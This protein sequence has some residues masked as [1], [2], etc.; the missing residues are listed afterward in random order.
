MASFRARLDAFLLSVYT[1]GNRGVSRCGAPAR[2]L[3]RPKFATMVCSLD[4]A[5]LAIFQTAELI[6]GTY[7]TVPTEVSNSGVSASR[8]TGTNTLMLEMFKYFLACDRIC[9][10]K[11]LAGVFR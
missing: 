1:A 8:G 11:S 2:T 9:R 7:D 4:S 10:R 6:S 5:I 3:G